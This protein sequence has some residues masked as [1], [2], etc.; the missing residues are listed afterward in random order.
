M[1]RYFYVAPIVLPLELLPLLPLGFS[2]SCL[3]TFSCF[4]SSCLSSSYFLPLASPP[5]ASFHLTSPPPHHIA[6]YFMP[7]FFFFP[8]C[9]IHRLLFNLTFS[10]PRS[11]PS[12]FLLFP[13]FCCLA[14]SSLL[15]LILLCIFSLLFLPLPFYRHSVSTLKFSSIFF[16]FLLFTVILQSYPCR[17]PS[18]SRRDPRKAR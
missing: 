17:C 18:P 5:L 8:S 16:P 10:N 14:L 3:S 13:V 9:V 7:L 2:F 4:F 11:S 1:Q 15:F 6:S 12:S